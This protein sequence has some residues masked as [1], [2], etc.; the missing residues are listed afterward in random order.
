MSAFEHALDYRTL[1]A[2][3]PALHAHRNDIA[4]HDLAQ[5]PPGKPKGAFS[6]LDRPAALRE[7][8]RPRKV[9]SPHGPRRS[10][11]YSSAVYVP[12]ATSPI[13]DARS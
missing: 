7:P 6:R 12:F 10:C 1:A 13:S 4:I 8:H 3:S 5:R 2:L 9:R 11:C